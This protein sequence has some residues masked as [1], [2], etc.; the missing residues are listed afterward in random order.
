MRFQFNCQCSGHSRMGRE[1][2]ME[3]SVHTKDY[4][5]SV[6]IRG[7]Q[8]ILGRAAIHGA[9]ELSWHSLQNQLLPLSLGAAIQQAAPHPCPGEE[10]F[11]EHLI[12]SIPNTQ[13]KGKRKEGKK[14]DREKERKAG[15]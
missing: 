12:L 3:L 2:A 1:H 11:W 13:K 5:A 8:R 10:R 14:A 6:R 7:A 4:E 15:V 9:I